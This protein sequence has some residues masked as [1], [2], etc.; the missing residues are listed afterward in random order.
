MGNDEVAHGT[1]TVAPSKA[2]PKENQERSDK[3]LEA[4]EK[5]ELVAP[6][7]NYLTMYLV[8][9][10][11]KPKPGR[12]AEFETIGRNMRALL[13]S[14]PGVQFVEGIEGPDSFY[15]VHAYDDEAAYNRIVQDPNGPFNRA[16]AEHGIEDVADW[17]SSVKGTTRG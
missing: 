12:E 15:A 2:N 4:S 7:S 6:A 9:S 10:Q 11:W 8:I 16:A 13:R 1:I 3:P 5:K 14:T 17:L